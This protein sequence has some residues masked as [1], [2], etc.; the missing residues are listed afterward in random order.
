MMAQPQRKHI[1]Q[2]SAYVLGTN[3]FLETDDLRVLE[4]SEKC[5]KLTNYVGSCLLIHLFMLKSK[6]KFLYSAIAN[7]QDCSKHSKN[8]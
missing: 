6:G 4:I 1:C 5:S 7:P 8:I 3:V 2:Y